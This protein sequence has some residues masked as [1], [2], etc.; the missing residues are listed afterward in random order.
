MNCLFHHEKKTAFIQI[1]RKGNLILC[2]RLSVGN[3]F[4]D[5][6]AVKCEDIIN[7]TY[8]TAFQSGEGV[9]DLFCELQKEVKKNL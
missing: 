1:T 4:P 3:T 8:F 2:M 6:I 7:A 9:D 5:R